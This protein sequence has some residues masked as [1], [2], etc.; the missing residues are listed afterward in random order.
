[1]NSN[2]NLLQGWGVKVVIDE[3]SQ[4]DVK[5]TSL[6]SEN[7]HIGKILGLDYIVFNRGKH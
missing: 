1:M 7:L 3:K 2:S 4:S 6:K 5:I